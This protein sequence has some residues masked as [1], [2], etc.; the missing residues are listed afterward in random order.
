MPTA[1]CKLEVL[2]NKKLGDLIFDV[3]PKFYSSTHFLLRSN[4]GHCS[5]RRKK[6]ETVEHY[7]LHCKNAVTSAV[8][9]L[10]TKLN[11]PITLCSVLRDFRLVDVIYHNIET[12][13]RL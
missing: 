4:D 1:Q 10:C 6:Q 8:C 5:N 12:D 13:R 3:T 9:E 7:L 2:Q 11:I